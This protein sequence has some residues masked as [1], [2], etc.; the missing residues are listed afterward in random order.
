MLRSSL[1]QKLSV[2][3]QRGK[4]KKEPSIAFSKLILIIR[5][6]CPAPP[7]SLFSNLNSPLFLIFW[8]SLLITI[9]RYSYFYNGKSKRVLYFSTNIVV[10]QE[11]TANLA[12]WTSFAWFFCLNFQHS[13][14]YL[15]SS[16]IV[17]PWNLQHMYL[18]NR[19]LNYLSVFL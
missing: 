7:L 12:Y 18:N 11:K 17:N 16:L 5:S 13:G 3:G 10:F 6:F 2:S 8:K 14:G 1:L 9:R 19:K 15:L 4:I